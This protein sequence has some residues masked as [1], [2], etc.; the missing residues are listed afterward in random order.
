MLNLLLECDEQLKQALSGKGSLDV[1]CQEA[2]KEID[3]R[4][5]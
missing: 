3:T 2:R 1:A 5:K 4:Q